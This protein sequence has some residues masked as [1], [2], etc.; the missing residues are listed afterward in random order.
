MVDVSIPPKR[1]TKCGETY[2]RTAEYFH[3]APHHTDGLASRCRTC[4]NEDHRDYK[5]RNPE[6]IKAE[7]AEYKSRNRKIIRQKERERYAANIEQERERSRKKAKDHPE[8]AKKRMQRLLERQP[9]YNR[10]R[11]QNYRARKQ[12]AQGTH[13]AK[14]VQKQY[15]SQKG[16][17]WWC[18]KKVGKKYHVDHRTPLARGGSDAPENLCITCPSCNMSKQDKMPWEWNGRLL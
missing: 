8:Q 15:Q 12:A 11:T 6:K 4:V 5:R 10:V 17:C 1:C 9:D 13:T 14:D 7:R 3:T 18:G 2:P 16:K